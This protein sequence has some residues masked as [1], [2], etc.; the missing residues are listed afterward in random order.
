MS[1]ITRATGTPDKILTGYGTVRS[2]EL[3]AIDEF[4]VEDIPLSGVVKRFG[5]PS[6]ESPDGFESKHIKNCIKFL[7]SLDLIE[8]SAQDVV[9][10][11][12]RDLYPDISFEARLLHHIRC[13]EGDEF[14]LAEIHDL[15]MEQTST[16]KPHGYRR[17]SEEDLVTLLKEES[18]F[19]IQWRSEKT[20]MWANLLTP[21]G[22]ISYTTDHNEIVTSPTRPLLYEL[23][24]YH[25]TNRDDPEGILNAL[26]WIH[27]EFIPVFY[28][29]SGAPRLHLGVADT[30]ENMVDD[31]VLSLVGMT[32]VTQTVRLP[33]RIDDTEEPARYKIGN[34]PDRPA[35]WYPLER[36]ERRVEP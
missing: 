25:Q 28:D 7:H 22:A 9:K 12:N 1:E 3:K 35:Y 6:A 10:P 17:I 31:E 19:D 27:E 16:E 11:I 30:L 13:Q 23:L 32:D 4:L 20:S 34:V 18:R 5:R 24:S 14:Q 15:L 36:S 26:E 2:A 29:L 21:I 33:Y 8:R